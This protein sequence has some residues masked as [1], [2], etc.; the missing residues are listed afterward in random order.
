MISYYKKNV[1]ACHNNIYHLVYL[2]LH[3]NINNCLQADEDKI[4]KSRE[5]QVMYDYQNGHMVESGYSNPAIGSD[6]DALSTP[7][8][9][10]SRRQLSTN[11]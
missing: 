8:T 4:K 5:K 7:D 10:E 1:Y 3:I 6:P 11:L 9:K 2:E